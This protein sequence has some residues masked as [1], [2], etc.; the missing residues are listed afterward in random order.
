MA[1]TRNMR[2]ALP[3]NRTMSQ[4]VLTVRV[5]DGVGIDGPPLS[6]SIADSASTASTYWWDWSFKTAFRESNFFVFGIVLGPW[7]SHDLRPYSRT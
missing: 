5:G 3:T 2:A 7:W 4:V 6:L 1:S